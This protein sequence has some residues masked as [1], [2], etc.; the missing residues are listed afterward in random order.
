LNKKPISPSMT[1]RFVDPELGDQPEAL[2]APNELSSDSEED[3]PMKKIKTKKTAFHDSELGEQPEA[4]DAP[5][6][7]SSDEF[8]E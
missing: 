8:S 6:D 1:R 4:F 2:E 7:L 3:S 5:A